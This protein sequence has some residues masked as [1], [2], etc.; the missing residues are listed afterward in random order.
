MPAG[1]PRASELWELRDPEGRAIRGVVAD[2]SPQFVT[3]VSLTGNRSRVSPRS[4]ILSWHFVS[5]APR[6]PYSCARRGCGSGAVFRYHRGRSPEYACARHLPVGTRAEVL[7]DQPDAPGATAETVA[8]S[9]CPLCQQPDPV[10]VLREPGTGLD[11][12]PAEV[13]EWTCPLCSGR[14]VM[15]LPLPD[16]NYSDDWFAQTL[17]DAR[18]RA[19]RQGFE[20]V[21]VQAGTFAWGSLLR[22]LNL[23]DSGGAATL[24][25]DVP[26]SWATPQPEVALT[27]RWMR[28]MIRT[29]PQRE[30]RSRV[31]IANDSVLAA[32][33]ELP[34][35]MPEQM[36]DEQEAKRILSPGQRWLRKGQGQTVEVIAIEQGAVAFKAEEQNFRMTIEDFLALHRPFRFNDS[37]ATPALV[38]P[39]P[40]LSPG[41]EWTGVEGTVTVVDVDSKREL[42]T[43]RW[44]HGGQKTSRLDLRQFAGDKW[45]KVIRK[46]AYQ[47]LLDEEDD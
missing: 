28:L 34:A 26:L 23:T 20:V 27:A 18:N 29:R 4:F 17:T 3:L 15:V 30:A 36:P 12:V 38:E 43:V 40:E 11:A 45:R 33:R 47:R 21:S 14:W 46:T 2:V 8:A 41:D 31:P 35:Q 16:V 22:A 13:S 37:G 44:A 25:N 1:D 24:W 9:P 10:E 42:V 7:P 19:S 39:L 32:L 5:A 6:T